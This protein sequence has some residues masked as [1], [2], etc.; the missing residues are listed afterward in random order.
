MNRKVATLDSISIP[1]TNNL[2]RHLSI[3]KTTNGE[4]GH[5]AGGVCT[6]AHIY[7]I[8]ACIWRRAARAREPQHVIKLGMGGG[9]GRLVANRN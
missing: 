3:V 4:L 2:D 9:G 1:A 8:S 6:Y 7:N 5:G